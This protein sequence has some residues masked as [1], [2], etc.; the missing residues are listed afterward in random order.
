MG[1]KYIEDAIAKGDANSIINSIFDMKKIEI[2]NGYFCENELWDYKEH[3]PENNEPIG[4]AEISKDVLAFYNCK[5]GVLIFGINDK[6][7][8]TSFVNTIYDSKLFNDKIRKYI[9]DS[10]FVEFQRFFIQEDQS[11]IGIALIPPRGPVIEKFKKN[12]PHK[13]GKSFFLKNGCAIREFDSSQVYSPEKTALK[14]SLSISTNKDKRFE[15]D[16]PRYKILAAEYKFYIERKKTDDEIFSALLDPR[17]STISL[18]GIGGVGKTATATAIVLKA[19]KSNKFNYI[20]SV[21]AKDRELTNKGIQAVVSDIS[22]YENLLNSILCVL[23]LSDSLNSPLEDKAKDV[24]ELLENSKSLIFVDNL[25]TIEDEDIINFLNKLP[26]G[27]KAIVTSRRSRIKFSAYPV[28]LYPF[29]TE[30]YIKYISKIGE[31]VGYQY[32]KKLTED[33]KVRIGKSC[34]GIPLAI[35]W[36]IS[37]SESI[38][39]L[40]DKANELENSGHTGEQLLEFSFR[41]VFDSMNK[42]EIAILKVISLFAIHISREMILVAS[43][44][45]VDG[46]EEALNRLINDTFV[47]KIYDS[48]RSNYI[49]TSLSI[50]KKF[51]GKQIAPAEEKKLRRRLTNWFNAEDINDPHEKVIVQQIR[52]KNE[53]SVENLI[54]MYKLTL[55]RKEIDKAEKLLLSGFEKFRNNYKILFNLGN[56]Y[57]LS[58]EDIKQ[59][60]KFYSKAV[61]FCPEEADEK[62]IIHREYAFALKYS[63]LPDSLSKAID[64]LEIAFSIDSNDV[65]T[66]TGLGQAY[67]NLGQYSKVIT[68]CEPLLKSENHRT[69]EKIVPLLKTAYLR[70]NEMIKL[71]E[72]KNKYKVY[73]SS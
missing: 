71:A 43:D 36:I 68:F 65:F 31:E 61:E 25:E 22:S 54:E 37:S 24:F 67:S 35:R 10:I 30:Q 72:L 33:Q 5:G 59:S 12:S 27:V 49:Y 26:I 32:V 70:E 9:G 55:N 3:I 39:E 48:G 42:Y 14:A 41:R 62:L 52:Q 29:E 58:K 34:D 28:E 8:K 64:N 44:L 46:I 40:L 20:V 15:I 38:N 56:F 23:G 18:V 53:S 7:F 6:S 60:L 51:I 11:Y 4:W 2:K 21:T 66:R 73:L 63:G 45:E 19:Y 16:E 69:L 17:Y 13:K 57:R 50:L 1:F 47:H